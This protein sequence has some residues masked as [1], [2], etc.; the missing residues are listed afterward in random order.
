M[1]HESGGGVPIVAV[2]ATGFCKETWLPVLCDPVL[3]AREWLSID[4]RG[5]GDSS[6]PEPPY[7]W[8]DLGRD[9]LSVIEVFGLSPPIGLG[10]SAGAAACLMAEIL[11]P[12]TF[13]ALVLIEPIVFPPPYGRFDDHPLAAGARRRRPWFESRDATRSA[14]AGRPPFQRWSDSALDAYVDNGFE[15]SD[16][17]RLL[18]C[19]PEVEAEFYATAGLHRAWDRLDEAGAPAVVVAG[20]RSLSHPPSLVEELAARMPNAR[21][22]FVA[23]ATHFVPMEAPAAVAEIVAVPVQ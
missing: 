7:D 9:L 10:H 14:F 22:Q 21:A 15:D 8:W 17:G 4:Q 13:S 2:H 19:L 18:K 23:G 3:E 5:H 1:A 6:S 16:G 11:R 12:G 20:E